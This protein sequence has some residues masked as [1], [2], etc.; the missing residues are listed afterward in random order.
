[1][2][3]RRILVYDEG[4]RLL[5]R[6]ARVLDG[7]RIELEHVRSLSRLEAALDPRKVGLVL[8]AVEQG[9]S[10]GFTAF[11]RARLQCRTPL[12]MALVTHSISAE[13]LA[14]HAKQ[15]RHADAYLDAKRLDDAALRAEL[16]RFV[17]L[18]KR[19]KSAAGGAS[20]E[21]A[22]EATPAAPHAE[23]VGELERLRAAHRTEL[24]ELRA[25]AA[26]ELAQTQSK[27]R[28]ALQTLSARHA[29]DLEAA[30]QQ[31]SRELAQSEKD[32]AAKRQS[33]LDEYEARVRTLQAQLRELQATAPEAPVTPPPA[34]DPTG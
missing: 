20:T 3:S 33:D 16:A 23:A 27:A 9:N 4:R 15:R 30:R 11:S 25:K 31:H 28:Q 2:S 24:E 18:V 21:A 7:Y 6:V 19:R 10:S 13:E 17:R 8:I 22:A 1:M 29:A 5:T 32:A 14:M 26:S 12:P 34:A